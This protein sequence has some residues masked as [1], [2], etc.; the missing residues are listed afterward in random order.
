MSFEER[1]LSDFTLQRLRESYLYSRVHKLNGNKRTI[2]TEYT[3]SIL[4]DIVIIRTFN[5]LRV[6]N[7]NA[8]N[9]SFT[10]DFC[11]EDSLLSYPDPSATRTVAL[12][13]SRRGLLSPARRQ[14]RR[15]SVEHSSR[16]P[17]NSPR[18]RYPSLHPTAT[19]PAP[20]PAPSSPIVHPTPIDYSQPPEYVNVLDLTRSESEEL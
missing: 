11:S 4:S 10:V 3:A 16:S 19:S 13:P 15:A 18:L 2:Q 5:V 20:S 6:D 1:F 17:S 7:G 8:F 9:E 12:P 14:R